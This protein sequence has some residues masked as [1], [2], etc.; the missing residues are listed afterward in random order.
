V[1]L[2][3]AASCHNAFVDRSSFGLEG[4]SLQRLTLRRAS[5]E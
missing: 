3:V 5:G 4:P 1:Q 2:S